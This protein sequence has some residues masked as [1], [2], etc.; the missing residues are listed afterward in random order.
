MTGICTSS[1]ST[2]GLLP[3]QDVRLEA[4]AE[5][6]Q[7]A[8]IAAAKQSSTR[9]SRAQSPPGVPKEKA[10]ILVDEQFGAAILRDA[11]AA[12]FIT[13]APARRAGRTN[14]ISNM[15]RNFAGHIEASSRPFARCCALT[16][17]GDPA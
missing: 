2:T 6:A 16:A 9:A 11:L 13:A 10:G 14:S 5:R 15:A 1:L 7:T 17:E 12:G 4:A 8:E 3:D